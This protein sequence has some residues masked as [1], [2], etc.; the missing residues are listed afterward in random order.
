MVLDA[1]SRFG[2][3]ADAFYR[4]VVQID[5][6]DFKAGGQPFGT[7][8]EVVVL[9]GDFDRAGREVADR[10]VA[11]VVAELQ[12]SALRS[13]R[14]PEQLVAEAD[15]HQRHLA[16]KGAD[17][18][19]GVPDRRRVGGAVGEEHPVRPFGEHPGRGAAG[20]KH[21]YAHSRRREPAQDVVLDPVV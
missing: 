10:V 4:V 21:G 17:H 20:R 18:F 9:A 3:V 15:A 11:A 1:E 12:P 5:M 6:G 16:E 14:Q 2:S 13:R 19:D 7:Q 8:G